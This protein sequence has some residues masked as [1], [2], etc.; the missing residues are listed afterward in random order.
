MKFNTQNTKREVITEKN[1]YLGSM[2]KV[3]RIMP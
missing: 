3:K 2:S 1:W